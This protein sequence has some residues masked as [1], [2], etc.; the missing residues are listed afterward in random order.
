MNKTDITLFI[1]IC[2]VKLSY[3]ATRVFEFIFKCILSLP[4]SILAP[5][6]YQIPSDFNIKIIAA[7]SEYGDITNK[8]KLF[9]RYYLTKIEEE[10][11]FSI[12]S[13]NK[14]LSTTLLYCCYTFDNPN[15]EMRPDQ[16]IYNYHYLF[17][18]KKAK[19]ITID[20]HDTDLLYNHVIL[21]E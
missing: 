10:E 3:L 15:D 7:V 21:T 2:M 1:T 18:D 14:L 19:K 16:F 20:N 12:K 8:F 17:I 5:V 9:L 11:G 13:F 4:N 6:S